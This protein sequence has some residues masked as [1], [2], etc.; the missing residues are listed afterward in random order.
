MLAALAATV[1]LGCSGQPPPETPQA[2]QTTHAAKP[3]EELSLSD[4]HVDGGTLILVYDAPLDEGSVPGTGSYLVEASLLSVDVEAVTIDGS[5]VV[6]TLGSEVQAGQS[7]TVSYVA[8][9]ARPLHSAS[10]TSAPPLRFEPAE[11]TTAVT[12]PELA[13][14]R[15]DGVFIELVYDEQLNRGAAAGAAALEAFDVR[16]GSGDR[17]VVDVWAEDNVATLLLAWPVS[18]GETVTVS[19]TPPVEPES[20]LQDVGG[21]DTAGFADRA[22]R[23]DTPVPVPELWGVLAH[24]DKLILIYSHDLGTASVPAASDF[25]VATP[26]GAVEVLSVA[27]ETDRVVLTLARP[28]AHVASP[29]VS[30]T[31]VPGRELTGT[32]GAVA[33]A[34][35]KQAADPEMP[36]TR[37]ARLGVDD[38]QQ[39]RIYPRFH[40]DV[41]HYALRCS[42]DD[43][44]RLSLSTQSPTAHV[45]VNA[46]AGSVAQHEVSGVDIH[47]D[48]VVTV[49]EGAI[50]TGYVL[51]CIPR[52]FPEVTVL[53]ANPASQVDLLTTALRAGGV[54]HSYIAVLNTDGVPVAHRRVDD[55]SVRQFKHHPGGKYP[56][57]YFSDRVEI[58]PSYE[59]D[60]RDL[61]VLDE[62]LGEVDR[63]S[64]VMGVSNHVDAHDALIKPNGNYV[65]ISYHLEQ[66]DLSDITTADGVTLS[67]EHWVRDTIVTELNPQHNVVMTWSSA[68]HVNIRDCLPSLND[69][70]PFEVFQY[71]HGNSLQALPDGDIVVSL[72]KCSQVFRIDY[73]SG[74]TVWK[75]GRSHSTSPRWRSNLITVQEDPYGEFCGQ[76]AAQILANGNLLLF[77]NDWYCQENSATGEPDR[78][79]GRFTRI[80][81]Y[82]LDPS[83]DEA[84]FLR[85]HSDQASSDTWTRA[86]GWVHQLGG[87]NWLISWGGR[88]DAPDPNTVPGPVASITEADP[89]TGEEPLRIRITWEGGVLS[90]WAHPVSGAVLGAGATGSG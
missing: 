33:D 20:R 85:H 50:A 8:Q 82:A 41:G 55:P 65:L 30:Y 58:N 29:V 80:V 32:A 1:L 45:S 54:D 47:S 75:V 10:G 69:D 16:V 61:V 77:D 63:I 6:L 88:R 36:E 60:T 40:P 48:I 44:L 23:N 66:R 68:D 15:A 52:D 12:V 74:D 57:S 21:T 79:N 67:A 38:A 27:V 43:T 26:D 81:E 7:V 39:R 72:R 28:V 73:P 25:S 19:Y 59:I 71:A 83:A 90:G 53:N 42:D 49:T 31:P 64:T 56:F 87:G 2:S 24:S 51:H 78:P 86:R 5:S 18:A 34:F 17:D 35:T 37:L 14:A 46:K 4:A 22:V 70:A 84:R 13:E 62:N 9:P 3:P 89:A 76:H 11:N